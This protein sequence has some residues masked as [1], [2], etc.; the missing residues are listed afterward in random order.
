MDI[1][2]LHVLF[3]INKDLRV[4]KREGPMHS[5]GVIPYHRLST[6]YPLNPKHISRLHCMLEKSVK[7]CSRF[8]WLHLLNMMCVSRN[9]EIHPTRDFVALHEAM[10]ADRVTRGVSM[11]QKFE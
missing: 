3:S 11:G 10:S 1:F 9:I 6:V 4:V 5:T 7:Q 2:V 8:V